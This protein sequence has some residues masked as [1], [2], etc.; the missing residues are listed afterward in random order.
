MCYND[1]LSFIGNNFIKIKMDEFINL[2]K[3]DPQV[4]MK[5]SRTIF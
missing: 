3:E 4:Q 1:I 5:F 2:I